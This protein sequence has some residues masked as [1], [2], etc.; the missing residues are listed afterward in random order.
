ML[1]GGMGGQ[2][3]VVPRARPWSLPSHHVIAEDEGGALVHVGTE[4]ADA[5]PFG[6]R[7]YEV[8]RERQTVQQVVAEL[9]YDG[10]VGERRC[11]RREKW[12]PML[13]R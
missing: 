13:P 5:Q 12:L 9:P 3:R 1:C 2:G 8:L 7:R 4:R 6:C 11:C 10:G